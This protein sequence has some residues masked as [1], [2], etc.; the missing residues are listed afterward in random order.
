MHEFPAANQQLSIATVSLCDRHSYYPGTAEQRLGG[1][2]AEETRWA[3]RDGFRLITE[4][5]CL[6]AWGD[7]LATSSDGLK[8]IQ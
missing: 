1:G 4:T 6:H 3:G 2:R 8:P 7:V 5:D